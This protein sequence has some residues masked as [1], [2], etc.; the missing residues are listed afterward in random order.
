MR[1]GE[2]RL[3]NLQGDAGKRRPLL[4]VQTDQLNDTHATIL[5]CA[6]SSHLRTAPEY[7][8]DV[9]PGDDNGLEVPSQVMIDKIHS[10]SRDKLS[11]PIGGL[12][13]S[14]MDRV[15]EAMTFTLGIV[16]D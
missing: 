16:P 1:R 11:E 6:L 7:R 8:L 2:L 12:D 13:P 10:I 15:T 9:E 3:G 4:V 5:V 14:M